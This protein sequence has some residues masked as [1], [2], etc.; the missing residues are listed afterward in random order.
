MRLVETTSSLILFSRAFQL[1]F[2]PRQPKLPV[3]TLVAAAVAAAEVAAVFAAAVVAAS[4]A[5]AAALL[6]RVHFS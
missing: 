3:N 4:F 6:E 2:L 1:R 5:A